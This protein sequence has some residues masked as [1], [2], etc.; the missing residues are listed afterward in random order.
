MRH[1]A[2]GRGRA[3]H[4]R[5]TKGKAGPPGPGG[6]EHFQPRSW[7]TQSHTNTRCDHTQRLART[8]PAPGTRLP[9]P[10]PPRIGRRRG[11]ALPGLQ[12]SN[13]LWQPDWFS[14]APGTAAGSRGRGP[15][16]EGRAAGCPTL[17]PSSAH[18][19]SQTHA[20]P[21]RSCGG[22]LQPAADAAAR[23]PQQGL[24]CLQRHGLCRGSRRGCRRKSGQGGQRA[25]AATAPQPL[26]RRRLSLMT[27]RL[28]SGAGCPRP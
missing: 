23:P 4:R 16:H 1:S 6:A 3:P 10:R 13:G 17:S 24:R 19:Q 2:R 7:G 11:Q 5:C 21:T 28:A 22:P 14:A 27:C 20:R 15:S 26:L 25:A 12:R 18:T 8:R 9:R